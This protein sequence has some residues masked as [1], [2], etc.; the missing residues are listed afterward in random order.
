VRF[1]EKP[2]SRTAAV[3][4]DS[5][6][7]WWNAGMF[8]TRADVLLGHPERLHPTLHEG[9]REIAAA[10]HTAHRGAAPE[11]WWPRLTR[12]AIDHAIAEPVSL[13][14]GVAV[15]PG[16]FGWTDVGD[17]AALAAVAPS[18]EAVWVE[19]GGFVACRTGQA[20]SV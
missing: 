19:A 3:Y 18:D 11:H 6:A 2:D 13:D 10:W 7:F 5:G 15:V 17:F 1:V 20:V 16:E 8:V 14:G 4:V 12:I 9:L